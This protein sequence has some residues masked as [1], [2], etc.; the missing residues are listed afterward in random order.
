MVL[1]IAEKRDLAVRAVELSGLLHS[2]SVLM[3]HEGATAMVLKA[4][5]AQAA[6]NVLVADIATGA[7]D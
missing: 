3:L 1:T 4:L 6:L 2:L 5:E 7:Q